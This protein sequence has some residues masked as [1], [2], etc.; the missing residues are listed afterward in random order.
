MAPQDQE[1]CI[2]E[3]SPSSVGRQVAPDSR[4]YNDLKKLI[5]QHS[6]LQKQAGFYLYKVSLTLGLL[7]ASIAFL[8]LVKNPYLQLLNAVFMAF[9]SAQVS[10][11]AHDAGHRQIARTA[12]GN[13]LL[14][15][16]VGNVLTGASFSYW[17]RNHN[18]HHAHVNEHDIDPD[19]NYP[20]F[21]FVPEQVPLKKG[22]W[23]SV[24]KYQKYF[25]FPI[26]LT[27]ALS[28]K[29]GS[30]GY[31]FKDKPK[32]RNL[33]LLLIGIHFIGYFSLVIGTLGAWAWAFIPIHQGLLGLFLGAVFAPNHKAMPMIDSDDRPDFLR[34]QVLTARNVKP[35]AITDFCY[36]GLNY[37]IEHHLFPSI[38]R[39]RMRELQQIVRTF[40]EERQ[41][42]YY[43]TGTLQSYREILDSLHEVSAP[44]REKSSA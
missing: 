44:L 41:V 34:R 30:L 26:L 2:I 12:K 16:F 40:C 29:G 8:L 33:E 20:M 27:G 35:G 24:V 23:R 42:E 13:D 7:A 39:N 37:Q 15:Y 10:Y 17:M 22:I 14:G 4:D 9:A 18:L 28:L 36:G 19:L 25:F 21:A 32:T 5:V 38:P 3:M 6:L 11:L 1:F 31:L 43:E